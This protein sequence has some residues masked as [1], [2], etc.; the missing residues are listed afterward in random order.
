MDGVLLDTERPY[1]RAWK[2]AVS[3]VAPDTDMDHFEDIMKACVGRNEHDTKVY[4]DKELGEGFPFSEFRAA[5]EKNFKEFEKSEGIPLLPGAKEILTFLKDEGWKVALATST[6][7]V[8]ATRQL[9]ELGLTE[10]FDEFIF[11]DMLKHSKPEPDIYLMAADALGVRPEECL[12]VEDSYNGM[13]SAHAAGMKAVMVP[14]VLPAT[15]EMRKIAYMICDSLNELKD[16][17]K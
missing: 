11:G 12:A 14:D 13:K 3:D 1:I 8:T 16:R 5:T 2:K 9:R 17:L 6:R 15:D 4:F 10:F 7:E